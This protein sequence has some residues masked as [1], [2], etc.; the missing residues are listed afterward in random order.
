MA[1]MNEVEAVRIVQRGHVEGRGDG[2]FLRVSAD[3]D[4]GVAGAGAPSG[5]SFRNEG[6]I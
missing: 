5:D 2:A 1:A 4:V 3:V 6:T